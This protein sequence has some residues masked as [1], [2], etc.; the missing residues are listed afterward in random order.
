M[1]LLSTVQLK[2]YRWFYKPAELGRGERVVGVAA[3]E[4]RSPGWEPCWAP[5]RPAWLRSVW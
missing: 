1:V 5:L 3:L 4:L 2:V